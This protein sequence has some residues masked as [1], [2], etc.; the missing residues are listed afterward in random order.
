MFAEQV[1]A[2]KSKLESLF[3][4]KIGEIEK[5]TDSISSRISAIEGDFAAERERYI[6]DITGKIAVVARDVS[7]LQVC[8]SHERSHRA[9]KESNLI[10]KVTDVELK[11]DSRLQSDK[12]GIEQRFTT[13]RDSLSEFKRVRDKGDDKFQAFV[14]EEI[15][16]L[17]NSL[18]VETQSREQ[19]DED[20]IQALNHYTKALQDALRIVNSS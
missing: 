1:T 10:L 9:D 8:I 5:A 12:L 20:I 11:I 7:N 16:S 6:A 14:L 3:G 2:A 17:K 4:S 19:S 15:A 13:L 18:V